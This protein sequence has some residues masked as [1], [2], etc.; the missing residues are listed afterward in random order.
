[1]FEAEDPP[2]GLQPDLPQDPVPE[3][4]LGSPPESM[5]EAG[6]ESPTEESA[7][8][9]GELDQ[10][11]REA[12]ETARLQ[13]DYEAALWAQDPKL[14][15]LGR[16]VDYFNRQL[17]EQKRQIRDLLSGMRVHQL[18]AKRDERLAELHGTLSALEL[19]R[20]ELRLREERWPEERK[21]LAEEWERRLESARRGRV[22]TA[23]R[24]RLKI[25]GI[26]AEIEKA[27]KAAERLKGR[28]YGKAA[29]DMLSDAVW[30]DLE[31][32]RLE[33]V[34][35]RHAHWEARQALETQ[36]AALDAELND[37][38]LRAV[39]LD[40]AKEVREGERADDRRWFLSA[41]RKGVKEL[42]TLYPL[43]PLRKQARMLE[44][45][46]RVILR[47]QEEAPSEAGELEG[48]KTGFQAKVRQAEAD[49]AKERTDLE[50]QILL[51]QRE[52]KELRQQ[53]ADAKGD[54]AKTAQDREEAQE[55]AKAGI[56]ERL[57]AL[58]LTF[59]ERKAELEKAITALKTQVAQ[60]EAA[61]ESTKDMVAEAR[62]AVAED[63]S[64][65]Q[66]EIGGLKGLL[67]ANEAE[68]AKV[69]LS[70]GS[71]LAELEDKLTEARF[72]AENAGQEGASLSREQAQQLQTWEQ[73]SS[74]LEQLLEE[75]L[76]RSGA[77]ES[78]LQQWQT[79]ASRSL[80]RL[81]EIYRQEILSRAG[82]LEA[83][84]AQLT[85]VD[86][87]L[88]A[89]KGALQ[90]TVATYCREAGLRAFNA[91][92][93]EEARKRL[94]RVLTIRPDPEAERVLKLIEEPPRSDAPAPAPPP[95]P[96]EP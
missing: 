65:L 59:R 22:R 91:G 58:R 42:K 77:A 78:M 56:A 49:W 41:F 9:A 5:R 81:S 94:R 82:E 10:A 60:A 68:A 43:T 26:R 48:V 83:W 71:S 44:T 54:D 63:V 47:A 93:L 19:R 23:E 79:L 20:E 16:Q 57:N 90:E 27:K 24:Y 76:S 64:R 53:A 70:L 88:T 6:S 33:W 92:D 35:G 30:G 18:E 13:A 14:R 7:L 36:L 25:A 29:G 84:K 55:A 17:E 40:R 45:K 69:K 51:K 28:L 85:E 87:K 74:K 32:A 95:G 72:A 89:S 62:Q 46:L 1:M 80:G 66:G 31:A 4:A 50:A 3:P 73:A 52:L 39:A 75:F 11:R 96:V 34:F 86:A 8:A 67:A 2:P 12:A 61:Q 15:E 38:R 21:R 37:A